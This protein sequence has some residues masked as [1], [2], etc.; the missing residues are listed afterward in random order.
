M[1]PPL[2]S[3]KSEIGIINYKIDGFKSIRLHAKIKEEM[4]CNEKKKM[5]ILSK[6]YVRGEDKIPRCW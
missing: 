6:K 4:E 1:M 2:I 3:K 5:E